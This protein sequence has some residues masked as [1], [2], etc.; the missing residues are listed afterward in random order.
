MSS[1]SEHRCSINSLEHL[2]K[3]EENALIVSELEE[4]S[5]RKKKELEALKQQIIKKR[6]EKEEVAAKLEINAHRILKQFIQDEP[7]GRKSLRRKQI[8]DEELEL[9]RG[10]LKKARQMKAEEMKASYRLTGATVEPITNK[11]LRICWDTF[12]QGE[13]FESFYAQVEINEES[14]IE[15]HSI[16]FFIPIQSLVDRYLSDSM[17]CFVQMVGNYLNAYV[18]RRQEAVE[19]E[20]VHKDMMVGE[21]HTASAFDFLQFYIQVTEDNILEVC[22][23]YTDLQTETIQGGPQG[24]GVVD[25]SEDLHSELVELK[26]QLKSLSLAEAISEFFAKNS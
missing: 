9:L 23:T 13:F 11:K 7:N 2:Q 21:V 8:N 26:N 10:A 14:K 20:T 12:H 5:H 18:S 4:T 1:E 22:V 15:K 16:P 24:A 17:E 25:D 3:L 6:N 19:L